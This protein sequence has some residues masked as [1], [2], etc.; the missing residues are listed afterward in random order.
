M[1]KSKN[2]DLRL[3]FVVPGAGQLHQEYLRRVYQGLSPIPRKMISFWREPGGWMEESQDLILL[4]SPFLPW[5]VMNRCSRIARRFSHTLSD[6]DQ[7]VPTPPVGWRKRFRRGIEENA[8]GALVIIYGGAGVSLLSELEQLDIPVAVN[9]CGSDAQMADTSPWYG[10]QL[11]RLWDRADQCIYISK[12]L[13]QQA[14][15]RGCPLEKSRVIYRGCKIVENPAQTIN[16]PT[17]RILCTANLH[18]VK[19]H[20]YLLEAFALARIKNKN[21]CL[22]LIGIGPQEQYL[23]RLSQELKIDNSVE[24][25]GGMTWDDVQKE[26]SQSNLYV[27]PSVKASDGQEE[28]LCNSTLEAQSWGLPT[29]VQTIYFSWC[30]YFEQI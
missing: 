9:F 3:G 16:G 24:F 28:G 11:K 6:R 12:F 14:C 20:K 15:Q 19:G 29:I 21:L 10:Q 30:I 8:I 13:M 7:M 2:A 17:L 23:R 18:P 25:L 27:Q 22:S 4:S 1:N 5:K 26:M